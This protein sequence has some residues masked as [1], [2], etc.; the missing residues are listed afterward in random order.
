[1][2]VGIRLVAFGFGCTSILLQG[3]AAP[4]AS[5]TQYSAS[6]LSSATRTIEGVVVS[7]RSVKVS[8]TSATGG[9]TG[10][11]L[12]GIAG[13]S[14]GRGGRDN[15]AGAVVGA[16]AGGLVGAAM[17]ENATKQDAFE[18]I[19]KS[20]VMGLTTII[21]TDPNINVGDKVF[22]ILANKP[23]LVRNEAK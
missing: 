15:L 3:C 5:N 18:Y 6:A 21:Q 1:M 12:G 10:A 4:N 2:N 9:G 7:K 11:A 19:V 8:G 17:E 14:A 13:S 22:V 16:V 20:D 23:V